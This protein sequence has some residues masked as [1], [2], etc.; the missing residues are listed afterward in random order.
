[1]TNPESQRP[2]RIEFTPYDWPTPGPLYLAPTRFLDF[3]D[4]AVAQFAH[5]ATVG[6]STPTDKAVRLFY[7]VRDQI[8]Y[9]PYCIRLEPEAFSASEVLR[10]RR[11]YC[12]PKAVLLA[13]AARSV[14]IPSAMGLSDVVNHFNSP[15]MKAAMG[16][17]EVFLHHGWVA[18]WLEDRWVKASP[19]FNAELCALLK[20]PP[21]EFNGRDDALLQQFDAAGTRHMS[22]LKDHGLWSD[23]P[24][25]RIVSEFAG[26][27]PTSMWHQQDA[28]ADFAAEAR[29][30]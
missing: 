21:T 29:A 17:R 12:I 30:G 9:D 11:S 15:R 14:G 10:S 2:A 19:A 27:Y 4:D 16:G 28:A 3:D 6:G 25:A 13:A 24:H 8:R 20:V 1:M 5:D 7:A 22:Y 26:Y 23:L 18:L